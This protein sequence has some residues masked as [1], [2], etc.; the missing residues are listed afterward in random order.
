M[1]ATTVTLTNT[2]GSIIFNDALTAT[3]LNTAAQGYNVELNGASGTITNAV[4]FSNTG[5]LALG[6]SG[7]TLTF[8]GGLTATAPSASTLKGTIASSNDAMSFGPIT[9]GANT[10]LNTVATTNVADLSIGAVTGATYNLTLR[11]GAVSGAEIAG[12]STSGVGTLTITNSGGT[13]FSGAVSAGSL[14]ITDSVASTAVTFNGDL[15]LTTGM[16]VSAGNAYNVAING[17]TNT[18]AGTTTFANTGTLALGNG[19]DTIN[20]TGGVIATAPS[21]VTLGGTLN[22]TNNGASISI[23]TSSKTLTLVGATS[24]INAATSG[25]GA[26]IT[27]SSAIQGTSV[28]D[29]SLSVSGKSGN[30][31]LAGVIGSVTKI[32]TLTL[33]NA[34]QTGAITVDGTIVADNLAVGAST[35]SNAFNV[36]LNNIA[37]A[38]G[39]TTISSG[40]TFYNTG[41]L[42]LGDNYNDIFNFLG[43]VT[44]NASSAISVN[45]SQI[46]ST[47]AALS[48]NAPVTFENSVTLSPGVG[49]ITLGAAIVNPGATLTLGA[50]AATPMT[51]S[52]ISGTSGVKSNITINTTDTVSV[53]GAIGTNIGT[54]TVTNSGGITFSGAVGSSADRITSLA[55][56]SGTGV[57]EFAND[58]YAGAMSNAGG[59]SEIKFYGINTDVTSAVTLSTTGAVYYG[60]ATSDTL[61]FARGI[62][63]NTGD[64]ILLGTFTAANPSTCVAGTS[65][66]FN[67]GG[68]TTFLSSNSIF[69]FGTS[70]ITLNNVLLGNGVTLYLGGGSSGSITVASITG[71]A[72]GSASNV[73]INTSGAVSV[74]GAIGTDI[75]TLTITNAGGATFGGA[76]TASTVAL[77]SATGT[78]AFNDVL[79]ANTLSTTSNAY[80]VAINASGSAITNAVTFSNTGTVSLGSSG[81]TQTYTGGITATAPSSSTLKGTINTTNAAM[82]FGPLTLGANTTLNSNA[83][84][85]AG[86]ITLGAVTASS[87]SLT[88][89]TGSGVS[90]ADVAGTS[91]TGT[92]S[93]NLQNIGGTASF[94][95]GITAADFTIANTVNNVSLT[96]TGG[97]VTNAITFNNTGS[98]TLGSAGNTQTYTAGITATAPSSIT[99]AGT[100]VMGGSTTLG[101]SDTLVTLGSATT[102]SA[103]A[104]G[105][106]TLGSNI[107]ASNIGLTISG[108]GNTVIAT[109]IDIGSGTLTKSGAGTLTLSGTNTYTGTT[110]VSAGTLALGASDVISNSSALTVNGGTL[111]LGSHSD[112]VGAVTIGS[113]GGSITSTTGVLTGTSYTFNNT[114]AATVSA[115][116]AGSVNLTQ[117]GS[118]TTTLS[119]ANTYSGTTTISGG[120]LSISADNQLGNAP[121]SA[122]TGS[123]IF[124]GGTLNTTA[125]FTLNANRGIA[126]TGNGTINVDGST[127]LTYNGIIAGAGDL[128]KSGAGTLVLG[129]NSTL[130]GTTTN[131]A[132][133]LQIGNGATSGSLGSGAVINS[134]IL[135]YSRSDDVI[136][137]GD[138][139]GAGSIAQ[140]GSGTLYLTGSNTYSGDTYINSGSLSVGNGGSTGSFGSGSIFNNGSLSIN[141]TGSISVS[142]VISGTGSLTKL[143]SGTLTLSGPNTYTGGTTINAGTVALGTSN[144]LANTGAVTVNGGT[145]AL[146]SYS[147]TVGA[148]T[149]GANGGSITSTTGV[150]TGTSYTFNNTSAATVSAILAGTGDL[151]QNASGTTTLSGTNTYT[152]GTTI[153][154]G[155]LALGASNVLANTGVVTV[156]GGTLALGSYSDTVGAVTIGANGGSITST[157][158]VLTGTSYTFN[159]TSAATV[160]AILAGTGDLT[161]NA[162]G[163]TTLSGANTYSGATIINAGTLVIASDSNLGVVPGS[164]TSTSIIF[165]GGTL[166]TTATFTLNANRG[167]S[168][169][170]NGTINVDGSTTLTYNGIITGSGN[171]TKSGAGTLILGGTNTY[172]GTTTLSAGTLNVGG[173]LIDTANIVVNNGGTY[174]VGTSGVINTITGSGSVALNAN[175]TVGGGNSAFT[176]DGSFAGSGSLIKTGAAAMTL[177]GNSTFTGNTVLNASTLILASADALGS[178]AVVS[179]SGT[180]QMASGVTLSSLRASGPIT[181]TSSIRTSGSQIYDGAVRIAGSSAEA[182][183]KGYVNSGS[184]EASLN[185]SAT[186]V[187]LS[188]TNGSITFNSTIDASSAKGQSLSVRADGGTVTIGNSVGSSTPLQHFNVTARNVRILADVKTSGEQSYTGITTIGTNGSD[189]FLYPEFGLTTRPSEKFTI[190][191]RALTRTFI[192]RDPMVRFVGTVNP[193]GTGYSLV[194]AAIYV[195]VINGTED[196]SIIP[197]VTVNGLVG[198][199]TPFYSTNFQALSAPN[200]SSLTPASVG[201]AGTVSVVG[202]ETTNT[203]N[204]SAEKIAVLAGGNS[205]V[206]TFRASQPG[207][208]DFNTALVGGSMNMTAESA[209]TGVVIDGLTNFTSASAGFPGVRFPI[210]EAEAA[211]RA[212]AAA[213]ASQSGG[214]L[215]NVSKFERQLA[216]R[217]TYEDDSSVTVQMDESVQQPSKESINSSVDCSEEQ[218]NVECN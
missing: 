154:A 108:A 12:T 102:L 72:G 194:L 116:L 60:D 183:L 169:T 87:Y 156:N 218:G 193:E 179:S 142:N 34:A 92:G 59:S 1:A 40:A 135:A 211:A 131:S 205:T 17:T 120:T 199:V 164:V 75:G 130:S 137:S 50:G 208:I 181:I 185:F 104:G 187:H 20:F 5:A 143:G 15:T 160:S 144:V 56:T 2:T 82:T 16:T 162:S 45:A 138:L 122:S 101:D 24:A 49:R 79:T 47:A 132:G 124:N 30:I 65:C 36:A 150:L 83:S 210:R 19:S 153:N 114:S 68:T 161:Q 180:L 189:G 173:S 27:I 31:S 118:G 66:S 110:T 73:V 188:S 86:D 136:L 165:D 166:N 63:H 182:L 171:L 25:T 109:V 28:G 170:S 52:S 200:L 178:G 105:T 175:L 202:V 159:N 197:R 80:N 168:M 111:A 151:T 212:A 38:A 196:Q 43:G 74:T 163:T 186:G 81:G 7:G 84:T 3:T 133:T 203:Q 172:T 35:G 94:T 123:I 67:L 93:L 90:G 201:L 176:F 215:S 39:T 134:A 42:R 195:G 216:L 103:V 21:A 140:S 125:S 126:M 213:A 8:N 95:G 78:I 13:T 51:L 41:T 26:T 198:N 139:S 206:A 61:T 107:Q 53:S 112:T 209:V 177:A 46:N 58:L 4:T 62:T 71:T 33:G 96:G 98:L 37:S 106:I 204:Y 22:T 191:S 113:N 89:S 32:G 207:N 145:L 6:A 29:Q 217:N 148:V 64:N 157:T 55:I 70:P 184:T 48:L 117:A 147:D 88:L 167:I 119:G 23:G 192:S 97:T 141:R 14:T 57:I 155:T 129:G 99:T 152:G 9:L 190:T 115:I 214:N 100:L 121:V 54:L 11:T 127:V 149:I 44:A 158:G 10:T 91:F 76:V 69:D 174:V 85:N 77:T 18:I 146:S 128:T